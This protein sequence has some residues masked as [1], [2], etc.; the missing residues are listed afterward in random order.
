QAWYWLGGGQLQ[1]QGNLQRSRS[2]LASAGWRVA[3]NGIRQRGGTP[4]RLTIIYPVQSA[5]FA[6]IAVQLEQM[7]RRVGIETVLEPVDGAVWFQRRNAGAFEVDIAGVH[8]DPSPA[9]LVQSWSCAS[10]TQ[11]RSGNVGRWCDGEFDRLL[12]RAE[13]SSDPVAAYRQALERMAQWQPAVVVGAPINRVAVHRR[14]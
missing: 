1:A 10:A 13:T 6:A 3:G 9:S 7:W 2:L 12:K 4:L 8:Q 11:R 5:S 14:Y